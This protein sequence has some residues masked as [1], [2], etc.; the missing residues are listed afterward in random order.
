MSARFSKKPRV[1]VGS[2]SSPVVRKVVNE[3]VKQLRTTARVIPWWK[4]P[5]FRPMTSILSGLL[6]AVNTSVSE[7]DFGLFILAADDIV[8][9]KGKQSSTTRDNVLFELGLFLG[10]Y[11]DERTFAVVQEAQGAKKVKIPSDFGGIIIPSF[12]P[13]NSRALRESVKEPAANIRRII[14]QKDRIPLSKRIRGQ[15]K[16]EYGFDW[17]AKKFKIVM[18]DEF[19]RLNEP[20]LKKGKLLLVAKETGANENVETSK[21]IAI[22]EARSLPRFSQDVTLLAPGTNHSTNIFSG[23]RQGTEVEGRVFLVPHSLKPKRGMIIN[24]LLDAGAEFLFGGADHAR[25]N[26]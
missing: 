17:D 18:H 25:P 13:K 12:N 9:S 11:G 16:L 8:L 7:Y 26:N 20:I 2:S 19:L 21:Q 3:F 6:S 14:T 10:A 23:I 5:E 15:N 4:S 22:S 24:D 1:F